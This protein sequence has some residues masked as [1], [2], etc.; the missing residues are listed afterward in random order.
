MNRIKQLVDFFHFS[1]LPE[2]TESLKQEFPVNKNVN[3]RL[4][5]FAAYCPDGKISNAQ[6]V[7]LKGLRKVCDNILFVADSTIFPQE[8]EKIKDIVCYCN[9]DRHRGFDFFSYKKGFEYAKSHGLLDGA[10]ELIFCNDSCYA[11]VTD[12]GFM[13]DEMNKKECDFWGI[14]SY[15]KK[16]KY[17]RHIQSYFYV[18]KDCVFNSSAFMKFIE[19]IKV[20]RNIRQV[21]KKYEL[22]LSGYLEKNGF[23]SA[24]FVP[25]SISE[26]PPETNKT[27][28]PLTLLEKYSVPLLKVKV[29]NNMYKGKL[30]ENA[31]ITLKYVQSVNKELAEIIQRENQF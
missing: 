25:D 4:C 6:L 13:F 31:F 16:Y 21:I 11:P 28:Y 15:Y 12:F 29:F 27:F 3:K 19:K 14:T 26:I 20:Q 18:F 10:E 30:A 8:V 24:T 1:K 17:P 7:Y 22:K 9:F 5:I 23:R 2:G